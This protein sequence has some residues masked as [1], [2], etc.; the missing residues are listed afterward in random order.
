MA[1]IESFLTHCLKEKKFNGPLTL[2]KHYLT[3]SI[4]FSETPTP[5]FFYLSSKILSMTK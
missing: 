2:I 1:Y 5:E 4:S 3:H